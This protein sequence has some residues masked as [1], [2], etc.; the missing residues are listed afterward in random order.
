MFM[1]VYKLN[2]FMIATLCS[3]AGK[4]INKL[5]T[6]WS[7]HLSRH[8]IDNTDILYRDVPILILVSVSVPIPVVLESIG[9]SYNLK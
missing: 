3:L 6:I 8:C 5:T 4:F 1:S 2:I 7:D 9:I